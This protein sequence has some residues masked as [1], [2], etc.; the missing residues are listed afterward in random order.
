MGKSI[1]EFGDKFGYESPF[2]N[3]V[4][5]KN[6]V[7]ENKNR[8]NSKTSINILI[9]LEALGKKNIDDAKNTI[10][11][12]FHIP[13]LA[14][15]QKII[16][17]LDK[18]TFKNLCI[19]HHGDTYS[20][21]SVDKNERPIL[22]YEYII[23]IEKLLQKAGVKDL[24]SL[25]EEYFDDLLRESKTMFKGEQGLRIL[26]LKAYYSLR[27]LIANIQK[28]G[29]YIS[30]ACNEADSPNLMQKLSEFNNNNINILTNS[31]F[32]TIAVKNEY[33][34]IAN[35]GSFLN[36]FL[37]PQEWWND[38]AGWKTYNKSQNEIIE[39]KKDL[40]LYSKHKSKIFDL[41]FRKKKLSDSQTEKQQW[42]QMYF[43]KRFEQQYLSKYG[44][45]AYK[46]FIDT[47]E[48]KYP[49]FKQ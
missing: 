35:Y 25:T 19:V 20:T 4:G 49:E 48:I 45:A 38:D 12:T 22:K 14:D 46:K 23:A 9:V 8:I 13:N 36:L 5:Q 2:D 27:Y 3:W 24:A 6:E 47:I 44:E 41:V 40:W 11:K 21:I 10:W 7:N 43:S 29:N 31:N 37:T 32:S 30:V 18:H 33:A 28:E 26:S 17:I 34:G 16:E 15:Y 39:T 1:F 42:A